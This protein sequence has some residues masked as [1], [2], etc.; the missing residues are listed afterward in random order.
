MEAI[1]KFGNIPKYS[2]IKKIYYC[3]LYNLDRPFLYCAWNEKKNAKYYVKIKHN[4]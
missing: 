2:K 1:I 4:C 3:F